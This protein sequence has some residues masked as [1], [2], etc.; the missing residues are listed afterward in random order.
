M[1]RPMSLTWRIDWQHCVMFPTLPCARPP[2]GTRNDCSGY[3]QINRKRAANIDSTFYSDPAT[4]LLNNRFGDVE[5]Q[6]RPVAVTGLLVLHAKEALKQAWQIFRCNAD[7]LVADGYS[8]L[9]T[10]YPSL[11]RHRCV[12]A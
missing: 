1:N 7:P 10:F 8:Q 5:A 4:V 12:F 2:R 11:Y 9:L 3:R 6:A